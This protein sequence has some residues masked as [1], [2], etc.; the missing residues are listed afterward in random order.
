MTTVSEDKFSTF[1]SSFPEYQATIEELRPL[2]RPMLLWSTVSIL[3]VFFG[4]Q[5]D[6]GEVSDKASLWGFQI[7]GL[8]DNKLTI[9][10]IL[11]TLYYTVRWLWTRHLRLRTFKK[12][13]FMSM[14]WQYGMPRTQKKK[15]GEFIFDTLKTL[16]RQ[17]GGNFYKPHREAL[18]AV[19]QVR[20]HR[21]AINELF[22]LSFSAKAASFVEHIA[23]PYV[24]PLA[25]ATLALFALV[26][27][28]FGCV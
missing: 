4:L 27:R 1:L 7:V 28:L 17:E 13:G 6:A 10:F 12:Q 25:I 23:I 22:D 2:K 14:L 16:R 9:F 26:V 5:L 15:E 21:G 18:D 11:T 20:S 8:T 3:Y 24:L 19:E